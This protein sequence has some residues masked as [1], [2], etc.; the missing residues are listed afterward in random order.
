MTMNKIVSRGFTLIELLV[1]IAIIALL[2][3]IL[4]P[5]LGAARNEAR[6]TKTA[7]NARSVA[8]GVF[9]YNA[10]FQG[11][12]PPAYVYASTPEGFNWTIPQQTTD[13]PVP[14]NGYI[15]WSISLFEDARNTEA[16]QSPASPRGGAPATNPGPNPDNWESGQVNDVG[17]STPSG[18]PYDRQVGRV[19][20]A[21]NGALIPRNKF[22]NDGLPRRNR[23]PRDAEP[24]NAAGTI[25]L[26][27]LA[28]YGG[29][30]RAVF[31][32]GVKSKSHRP[33]MPFVSTSGGRNVLSEP[34][35][36]NIPRFRYPELN[37]LLPTSQ[38]LNNPSDLWQTTPSDLN[39]VGRQQPGSKGEFGGMSH[40]AF[41]DGH[42]E[43][44]NVQDT[45]KRRLWG[46]RL[47]SVTG[48]GTG[49]SN[50]T[51]IP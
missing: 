49:I 35:I 38:I 18:T 5:A 15:H 34:N 21:P 37:E 28:S 14:A 16:F 43:R 27:E 50:M 2:V 42:V 36:G 25:M 46:D 30:W 4:L 24:S 20:F 6:A 41:A 39:L 19:A 3:G 11:Q 51:P 7:S 32:G 48:T 33:I 40:F 10:T 8:L 45:L 9:Q 13:H 23:L 31:E 44:L 12:M 29:N 17:S 1:V 26:S 47:W 22:A